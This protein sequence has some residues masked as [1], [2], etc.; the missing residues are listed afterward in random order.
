MIEDK[1]TELTSLRSQFSQHE[2]EKTGEIASLRRQIDEKDAEIASLQTNFH[3]MAEEKM[4]ELKSL[5][6]QLDSAEAEKLAD[7][8][9]I[10]Y[11]LV[12]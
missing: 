2:T 9:N 1:N 6:L 4:G 3:Q 11:Q 8:N 7:T 5:Q 10:L 12:S